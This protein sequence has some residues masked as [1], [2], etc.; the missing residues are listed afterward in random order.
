MAYKTFGWKIS[1]FIVDYL[2]DQYG[3][4]I[5]DVTTPF[6][7]DQA[8]ETNILKTKFVVDSITRNK[9]TNEAYELMDKYSMAAN[10]N[11]SLRYKYIYSIPVKI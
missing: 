9:Y 3:G 1:P 11:E 6:M 8:D 7:T 2:Y 10:T 5:A 4:I